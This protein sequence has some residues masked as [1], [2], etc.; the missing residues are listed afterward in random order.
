MGSDLGIGRR[1]PMFIVANGAR[2]VAILQSTVCRR[3]G[4]PEKYNRPGLVTVLLEFEPEE[5]SWFDGEWRETRG[6]LSGP[7]DRAE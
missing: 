4:Q 7:R 1:D 3:K 5:A 6:W 2:F